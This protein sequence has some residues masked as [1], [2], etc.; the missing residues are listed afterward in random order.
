M[1]FGIIVFDS[2]IRALRTFPRWEGVL[3]PDQ[4]RQY[5]ANVLQQ[6]QL[7]QTVKVRLSIIEVMDRLI[8]NKHLFKESLDIQRSTASLLIGNKIRP[9]ILVD[10]S[11][12]TIAEKYQLLRAALPVGGRSLTVY[13]EVHTL[14]KYNNPRVQKQFLN[15][16]SKVLPKQ[17]RPIIV[18]D[19]GFG[20]PW[21]K[22]ILNLGWNFVG[23]L[24]NNSHY[25]KDFKKWS[26]LDSLLKYRS[27]VI[28]QLGEIFL[29][30]K[31]ELKCYLQT[32]KEPKK[33][34][35]KKNFYGKKTAGSD[36]K[37]NAKSARN[38]WVLAHSL[39]KSK[40]T[41]TKVVKIYAA[42]M[43][44][45]ESFRDIKSPQFGFGLKYSRS[46]G[47]KRLTNLFLIGLIG[48][49]IAWLIG[50]CA[51]NRNLHYALQTNTIRRRNVLSVFFIG[52]QI[53]MYPIRFSKIEFLDAI[54]QIKE[55]ANV[56]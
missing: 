19:A 51:K 45:E 17:C 38:A 54:K 6:L 34:R 48:T 5:F 15:N 50:L 56:Y 53:I 13:E 32:H 44:I 4:V 21:F 39:G 40:Q 41:A 33:G 12:A 35:I 55:F 7:F 20:T 23:R 3:I 24:I 52:C 46:M 30:K 11:S 16:L 14:K 8:G 36:S 43:Q 47:I 27:P 9:I 31:H 42:R 28:K 29:S 37:R 26:S 2:P 25:T 18:T 1:I 22:D 10:W 49:L